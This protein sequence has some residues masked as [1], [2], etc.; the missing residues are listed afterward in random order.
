MKT[1][2]YERKVYKTMLE[3]K[4]KLAPHHALFLKGARRVGKTTL[5]EKLGREAY[6]TYILVR[7]DQAGDDVKDLFINSLRD[8]DNFY[9]VLQ[10][11]Y[12]TYLHERESLIILDEIQLFPQA[13]QAVKTLLEDGRYDILET[14]SL[15]SITK[16]S[17]E[18]LI[19]SE[20]YTLEVLPM[21][22]EEFLWAQGDRMTVPLI[23]R[24]YETMKP[25]KDLHRPIM[26]S[27]REY[28]MVGGMPQAV[29]MFVESR[30]YG[31]VD[32]VKQQI[33][34]LY[35]NDMAEQTDERSEYVSNFFFRIPSELSKHD[36]RYIISHIQSNARIREYQGPIRWLD[37][38]MIINIAD[39]VDEPSAALNLSMSDPSFKCYLM[40]TGLLISLAFK[41]RPI[42]EN[43][44]YKQILLDRL[45]VNEGMLIENLVSQCLRANGHP[46]YFYLER[47]SATRKTTLEIDFL[48]RQ[49]KK[50][51]PIEVKSSSSSSIKSLERFKEKY[52]SRIADGIVLHHGELKREGTVV[53]LPYFMAC[54]L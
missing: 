37:E 53:F 47:N 8:L 49:N 35:S 7:F 29:K 36:K 21:D 4:E 11:L 30:D 1:V 33:I 39:C 28:M 19:P 45:Q 9:A 16:R 46:S 24:H 25:L 17:K 34:N 40:D 32:L 10:L 52:G 14:G 48:I 20:E 18:I 5:A 43:D 51:V 3:W 50:I 38:A 54:V 26:K 22:F 41:D 42:L 13:R 6:K 15:A 27:F 2:Q 31:K 44:L 12:R 23:R